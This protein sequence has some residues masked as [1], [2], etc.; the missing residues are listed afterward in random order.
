MNQGLLMIGNGIR[1]HYHTE[2]VDSSEQAASLSEYCNQHGFLA[3]PDG[4]DAVI[5]PMECS[6]EDHAAEAER[7]VHML[8]STWGWFWEHSD[9]GLFG[10]TI[11]TRE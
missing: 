1:I 3:Y 4:D 9:R 7:K 5:I 10:L 8:V 2:P 11:Y 6:T